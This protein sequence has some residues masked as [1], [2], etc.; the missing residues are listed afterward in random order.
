MVVRGWWRGA[1]GGVA[2]AVD[3]VVAA[4]AAAATAHSD[5]TGTGARRGRRTDAAVCKECGKRDLL[6][7]IYI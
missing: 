3:A 5:T 4:A 2:A 1:G 7:N 6:V